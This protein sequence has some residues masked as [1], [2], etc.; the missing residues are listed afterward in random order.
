MQK[1]EMAKAGVI[2]GAGLATATIAGA[3]ATRRGFN[4]RG[5]ALYT[6]TK[7]LAPNLSDP[8]VLRKT[9]EKDRAEGP[10]RPP[11]RLLTKIDFRE[12][13]R[14]GMLVFHASRKGAPSTPLRLMYLHGGA[15]VL[16]LQEIQ[17]NLVIGLLDRVDAEVV[18]PIYPLGPEASWR[19][20]TAAVKK[21]DLDMVAEHG[22]GNIVVF[23]DS[24]GGGLAL[25][26]AQA[27]RDEGLPQPEALVLFSPCLDISGS[28]EDQPALERRDPALSLKLIH[29]IAP[30][31]AKDVPVAGQALD[32]AADFILRRTSRIPRQ[33][34][35]I[36]L[37]ARGRAGALPR[38][39]RGLFAPRP[40]PGQALDRSWKNCASRSSSNR[41][42]A[43]PGR[44][45]ARWRRARC[46][47]NRRRR[48]FD[49]QGRRWS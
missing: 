27:L 2:A 8:E 43:R 5:W 12:E 24:A 14:D 25:L 3:A 47:L 10:K 28:G 29:Q 18:A 33:A 6:L 31:W 32:E 9:I 41:P 39:P 20:T 15:F 36:G 7:L 21:H 42:L 23:G 48:G 4:L 38:A 34:L 49:R 11:K 45:V 16:D 37:I 46:L 26:L 44:C 35:S 22:A 40:E 17:W 13:V 19:E 1:D 30:M